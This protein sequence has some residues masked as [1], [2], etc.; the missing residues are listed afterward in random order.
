PT[1]WRAAVLSAVVALLSCPALMH[2]ARWMLDL[3]APRAAGAVAGFLGQPAVLEAA[4][5]KAAADRDDAAY[6][7][8]VAFS[9][10]VKILL[11]PVIWN[12]RRRR[13]CDGGGRRGAR[14]RGGLSGPPRRQR[15][16]GWGR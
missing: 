4:N 8:H 10:V 11:V 1:A 6:A 2:A 13:A 16:S 7:T 5:A 14:R 9:I 15:L 12:L 3:T